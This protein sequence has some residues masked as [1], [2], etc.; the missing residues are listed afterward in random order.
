MTD[1]HSP[2]ASSPKRPTSSKIWVLRTEL[3]KITTK[4]RQIY[5]VTLWT[6]HNVCQCGTWSQPSVKLG[7]RQQFAVWFVPCS[8][9]WHSE[10]MFV[11]QAILDLSRWGALIPLR[12][13]YQM[14]LFCGDTYLGIENLWL[15]RY[16]EYQHV[17]RSMRC[18][19]SYLRILLTHFHTYFSYSLNDS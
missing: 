5:C 14:S 11:S 17:V 18:K 7:M 15:A 2:G 3:P 12:F 6:K 4:P 16:R 1:K 9:T 8:C 13:E 10:L 19:E